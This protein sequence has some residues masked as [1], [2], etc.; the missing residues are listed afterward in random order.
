MQNK[1][2]MIVASA[3]AHICISMGHTKQITD[4]EKVEK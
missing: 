1:V 3:L 4:Q 2:N